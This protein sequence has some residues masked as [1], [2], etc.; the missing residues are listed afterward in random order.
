M[1]DKIALAGRMTSD[2]GVR[3]QVKITFTNAATGNAADFTNAVKRGVFY[4]EFVVPAGTTG[5]LVDH[6]A[7]QETGSY[8]VDR[9]ADQPHCAW[10]RV[11]VCGA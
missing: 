4:Q 2:G 6:I 9:S 10:N 1:G 7:H 8:P 11:R 3:S 5:V